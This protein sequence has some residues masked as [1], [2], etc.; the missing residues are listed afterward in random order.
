[1]IIRSRGVE[2]SHFNIVGNGERGAVPVVA[3]RGGFVIRNGRVSDCQRDGVWIQGEI[4]SGLVRSIVGRN[5]HPDTISLVGRK[6]KARNVIVENIRAYGS[7]IRG[8]L[9]IA[10]AARTSSPETSTR[11]TA[12]TRSPWRTTEGPS[13]T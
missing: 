7:D 5:L 13:A 4:H 8:A 12:S 3:R 2:V 10:D 9:E 1:M 6:P 11:R